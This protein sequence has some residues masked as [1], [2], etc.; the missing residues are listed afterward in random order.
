MD[1]M[2]TAYAGEDERERRLLDLLGPL[3]RAYLY[4]AAAVSSVWGFVFGGV[5]LARCAEPENK[6]LGKVCLILAVVNTVVVGLC[7]A[8]YV[9]VTVFAVLAAVMYAGGGS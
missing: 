3:V 1:P 4:F 6:K 7:V 5:A 8:I 9:A 2:V